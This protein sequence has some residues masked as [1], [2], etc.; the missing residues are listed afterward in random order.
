[1]TKDW[2]KKIDDEERA[3]KVEQ[4]KRE[5]KSHE[6]ARREHGVKVQELGQKFRCHVC[7]RP[8]QRPGK[9]SVEIRMGIDT[10]YFEED[11]WSKPAD[12]WQC[13]KCDQWTC[14]EHIYKGICKECAE[15][16]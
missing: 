4:E 8:A 3:R 11:D 6:I 14:E 16:M 1:M 10:S 15:K 12:L 13:S 2:K 7:N 9:Q 5:M